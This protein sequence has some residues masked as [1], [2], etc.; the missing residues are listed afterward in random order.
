MAE[1]YPQNK[2]QDPNIG[3]W[4]VPANMEAELESAFI[5]KAAAFRRK[6]FPK[7]ETFYPDNIINK[8]LYFLLPSKPVPGQVHDYNQD[9]RILLYIQ[10]PKGPKP[11]TIRLLS[12]ELFGSVENGRMLS[13]DF[14]LDCDNDAQ[15]FVDFAVVKDNL[16]QPNTQSPIFYPRK[17]GLMLWNCREFPP[18]DSDG[19]TEEDS[20]VYLSGCYKNIY[21]KFDALDFGNSL[22]SEIDSLYPDGQSK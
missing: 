16:V 17:N 3:G 12:N 9:R 15:Y 6:V 10:K 11:P 18:I 2:S 8:W 1:A 20:R 4:S 22:F 21:D 5:L 13:E 14:I 7:I 19:Q